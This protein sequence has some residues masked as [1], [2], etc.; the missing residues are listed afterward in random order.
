[1]NELTLAFLDEYEHQLTQVRSPADFHMVLADWLYR[2][3]GRVAAVVEDLSDELDLQKTDRFQPH[4]PT[5]GIGGLSGLVFVS[6]NPGFTKAQNDFEKKYRA[7]SPE[8]NQNFCSNL[9]VFRAVTR[10]RWWTKALDLAYRY[11]NPPEVDGPEVPPPNE[12]WQWALTTGLQVANIDLIPFHSNTDGFGILQGNDPA[13]RRL[14]DMASSSLRMA[15]TLDPAP[16]LIFVGSPLGARLTAQLAPGLGLNLVPN[17]ENDAAPFDQIKRYQH[18]KTGAKVMTFPRQVFAGRLADE[19][20]NG[21]TWSGLAAKMRD[22]A[23][24]E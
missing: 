10:S 21:F 18:A 23:P 3:Q 1:M 15:L 17:P 16:R 8:H 12:R 14:R 11:A 6:A 7:Q 24:L 20:P 2:N 22:F 19:R 9:A 13:R 4:I 5:A